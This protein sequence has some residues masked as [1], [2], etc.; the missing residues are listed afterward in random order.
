MLPCHEPADF[1]GYECGT[2]IADSESR[3]GGTSLAISLLRQHAHFH[4]NQLGKRLLYLSSCGKFLWAKKRQVFWGIL[5]RMPVK[6]HRNE[7]PEAFLLVV[8]VVV[9]LVISDGD[10]IP[11]VPA[12]NKC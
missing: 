7:L 8:V 4:H 12:G 6:R 9:V 2:E 11:C 3:V 5:V 1:L 10:A